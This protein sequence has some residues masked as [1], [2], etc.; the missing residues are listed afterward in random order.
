M[1]EN[2]V[3][4]NREENFEHNGEQ[5]TGHKRRVRYSGKYPKKFSEKYKERKTYYTLYT[6]NGIWYNRKNTE[7]GSV[8]TKNTDAGKRVR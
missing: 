5:N 3:E 4:R 7:L 8:S 2:K 1:A 6:G